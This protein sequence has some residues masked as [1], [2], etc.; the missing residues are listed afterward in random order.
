MKCAAQ[1]RDRE[2]RH[3]GEYRPAAWRLLRWP[4]RWAARRKHRRRL[5]RAGWWA[6]PPQ[7]LSSRMPR[8]WLDAHAGLSPRPDTGHSR[9]LRPARSSW[10]SRRLASSWP[11]IAGIPR[12]DQPTSGRP[13]H[14]SAR[15]VRPGQLRSGR[16]RPGAASGRSAPG[17]RERRRSQRRIS[18][19]L[20][21]DPSPNPRGQP[22]PVR[23]PRSAAWSAR[24]WARTGPRR[25]GA[26]S[27]PAGW[28]QGWP[29]RSR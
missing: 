24:A 27:R 5:H 14:R 11:Q 25:P 16:H 28:W 21:G 23:S 6:L 9:S 1:E 3:A 19:A 26:L 29:R 10:E 20:L 2:L 7:D 12:A 15:T 22:S 4:G 8:P 18:R 17:H 13:G